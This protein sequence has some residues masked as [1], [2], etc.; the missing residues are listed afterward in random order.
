[1][2]SDVYASIE[3]REELAFYAS[4]HLFVGSRMLPGILEETEDVMVAMEIRPLSRHRRSGLSVSVL[5]LASALMVGAAS[6]AGVSASVGGAS[7][8]ASTSGPGPGG[9]SA[10]ASVGGV[11]PNGTAAAAAIGAATAPSASVSVGA[12]DGVT[13][14]VS[15]GDAP[16]ATSATVGLGD[17]GGVS[18]IDR[19]TWIAMK[20]LCPTILADPTAYDRN[21]VVL[22][23]RAA[24]L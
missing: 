5:V 17:L 21:L 24:H 7:A 9:A 14:D 20:R 3:P 8:S 22:C 10:S 6:G 16:G 18:G 1:V 4:I 15:V 19:K 2:S 13:G 11:G 12:P 23:R